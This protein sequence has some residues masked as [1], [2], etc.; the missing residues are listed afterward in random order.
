MSAGT[1][2]VAADHAD[3]MLWQRVHRHGA[4]PCDDAG[5]LRA[6]GTEE[7][8]ADARVH[9]IG[10]DQDICLYA[11]AI[12]ES[13]GDRFHFLLEADALC[14]KPDRVALLASD[15]ALEQAEEVRPIHRQIRIAVALDRGLAQV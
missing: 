15:R 7:S 4:A 1:D 13:Q 10:P 11:F 6:V 14:A 8:L 5:E 9:A 3:H 12:F 2:P